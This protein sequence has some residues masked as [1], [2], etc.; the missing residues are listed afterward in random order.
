MS[1]VRPS[2]SE[3]YALRRREVAEALLADRGR[4]S[5]ADG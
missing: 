1:A 3:Q 5:R 2:S 4:R